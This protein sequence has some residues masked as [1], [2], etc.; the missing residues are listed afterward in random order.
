MKLQRVKILDLAGDLAGE[1]GGIEMGDARH[2]ALAGEQVPPRLLG[3]VA[4][5]ANHAHT[6]DNDSAAQTYFPPFACLSM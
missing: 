1:L 4:H 2:A 6:G 3:G 5:P